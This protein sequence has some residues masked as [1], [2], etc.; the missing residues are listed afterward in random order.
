MLPSG[1][2]EQRQLKIDCAEVGTSRPNAM[3]A[4]TRTIRGLLLRA[5]PKKMITEPN[6]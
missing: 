1:N 4:G 2:I 6:I 5:S 3:T